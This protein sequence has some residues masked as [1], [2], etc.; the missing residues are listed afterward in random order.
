MRKL[1]ITLLLSTLTINGQA[2]YPTVN[3]FKKST[4]K[5]G[6]QNWSMAQNRGG[7]MWFANTGLLEYDG[8][9]WKLLMARN[10]TTIRSLYYDE[11]NDRLYIGATNELAY[12]DCSNG[13]ADCIQMLDGKDITTGEIWAIHKI[14]GN[15][16]FRDNSTFYEY[17]NGVVIRHEFRGSITCSSC[18]GNDLYISTNEEGILKRTATGDFKDVPGT[19]ALKGTRVCAIFENEEDDVVFVTARNGVFKLK[20]GELTVSRGGIFSELESE[21]IFCAATDGRFM[22]FGTVSNGVYIY[23]MKDRRYMHLNTLSGLQ[24]NTVLSMFH[25]RDGNLWLGL[26]KGIDLI[27]LSSPELRIFDD[28]ENYGT[29]YA[30]EVYDG[31]L[32]LG[33]NQGLFTACMKEINNLDSKLKISRF[34]EVEGQVWSMLTYDGHLFCS[35]DNGISIIKGRET[36]HIN[37]NGAWKLEPLKSN[38]DYLLGSTYDRMF[39]LRKK[40]GIWRFSSWVEGFEE[41][42]KT[43]EEDSDGRI[44][45]S[46]WIK[47]LFL[48]TLDLEESRIGNVTYYSKNSGLPED[49]GNVPIELEGEVIFTTVNGLYRHDRYSGRMS[50]MEELNTRL[51]NPTGSA[52]IYMSDNGQAYISNGHTQGVLYN[53]AGGKPVLDTLSLRHMLDNRPIGFEHIRK[54]SENRIMLNTEDGFS[55]I[56]LDRLGGSKDTAS[57]RVFIRDIYTRK[58]QG[59]VR[60]FA[61]W[62]RN[63]GLRSLKLDYESNTLRFKVAYPE[64]GKGNSVLYSFKLE[65]YDEDWSVHSENNVKEYTKLPHGR[66]I[67]RVK[68]YDSLSGVGSEDHM[69]I[70]ISAP[71]YLSVYACIGYG[72]FGILMILYLMKVIQV[73]SNIRARKIATKKEEEIRHEQMS[74]DLKHKADD[75]AESTMNLI[76]KNEIL[77]DIDSGLEK[78][79][80]IIVEDRNRSL[81]LLGKLRKEIKENIQHDNA[82]QKFEANFDVVYADY[83]KRLSLAYPNLTLADKKMCAYLKM[84]LTSKEIAPL[85]NITVR[86]VEMT[87]YRLRKKLGLSH[88]ENLTEFLHN[89]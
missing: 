16:W 21:N 33:T 26:D 67:F 45:F 71:W 61:S 52:H 59:E 62:G 28:P 27:Q 43:F 81:K 34:K 83:L 63:D 41:A 50:R 49:W 8:N 66:Y 31:K 42:S 64:Y 19:S 85:L 39:L 47:G 77:L 65:N 37:M 10:R 68:A 36:R 29:G 48:L 60:K 76:R 35:H 30:S 51:G 40:G 32:W 15:I 20:N 22:S 4:Y 6:G 78:M 79:A 58:S 69:E 53:D 88:E 2:Y 7:V 80:D 25:D 24:N 56:R 11:E 70:S 44:W 9:E 74:L 3:N 12:I 1:L 14:D 87:R 18:I 23:D 57:D 5:A 75:L 84:D 86:S 46:H 72:I 54:V 73:I 13:S 55:I 89:F 82:W 17:D 38:P